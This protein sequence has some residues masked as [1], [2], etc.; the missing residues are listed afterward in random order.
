MIYSEGANV[1]FDNSDINILQILGDGANVALKN[2]PIDSVEISEG[3]NNVGIS[4]CLSVL[5]QTGA[6]PTLTI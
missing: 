5:V 1:S 3:G 4:D 6:K 2:A